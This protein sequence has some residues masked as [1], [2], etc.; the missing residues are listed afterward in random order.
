[1]TQLPVPRRD[2]VDRWVG[3]HLLALSC[4]DEVRRSTRFVGTQ[5]AADAA[6]AGLDISGYAR[7]RNEVLPVSARGA[8]SLSPYIR[9]GLL[10]L[11]AVSAAVA[12]AP[13]KDRQKFRDELMWQE[14]ARHVY[15]RLGART[16]DGL[17]FE[18]ARTDPAPSP[19]DAWDRSMA[20]MDATVGE[21]ETDG[22][23]VNQTRMWLASQWTVRHGLDWRTGEDRFFTHLLDGSRAANRLGWQWTV[24]AGTGKP[25]GFSRWQVEKRA[26]ELCARCDLRRNCPVENWPDER[27]S[28]A[29]DDDVR[30][31]RDPDP[32]ATAGP[33]TPQRTGTP[34]AVWLT[35]ESLG[36]D[37]PALAAHREL[38][39][40]FVYDEALLRRLRLSSKRLVFLSERLAELASER[41]VEIHLGDPAD[42]L[43][44]RALATTF[45]PVPKA[46]SLRAALDVVEVHPWPWL[47]RPRSGSVQSFSAWRRST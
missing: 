40:V 42:V 36:H 32:E 43:S 6:L 2:D 44:G 45:A 33:S 23:L 37:D 34:E 3:E 5:E 28:N 10:T 21:L 46:R 4:D 25:Y 38:P 12:G 24:G 1:M 41:D 8:T 16:R 17:R 47:V 14:Y 35:A 31:R 29:V 20:C 15:A 22:W 7:R 39:V 19:T 26:P 18:P 11:P 30:V 9:H 13:S 27:A